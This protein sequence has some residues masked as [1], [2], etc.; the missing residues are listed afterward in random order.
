[1]K[2][3][4]GAILLFALSL[5]VFLPSINVSAGAVWSQLSKSEK[6]Q[7]KELYGY[8]I[9]QGYSDYAAAGICGN[10]DE[11]TQ[12]GGDNTT[13]KAGESRLGVF[14]E[15]AE[16][17]TKNFKP[18]AEDHHLDTKSAKVEFQWLEGC[19]DKAFKDYTTNISFKDYKKCTDLVTGVEGFMVAY[20][21]CQGG[22][23]ANYKP[24]KVKPKVNPDSLYQAGDRRYKYA[25]SIY[26]A[27]KGT[28]PE[29]DDSN[30][31]PDKTPK[32]K[33]QITNK[34]LSLGYTEDQI[35]SY[36]RLGEMN[37]EEKYLM[38]TKRNNLD[39]N[40]V[41]NLA[42]WERNVNNNKRENGFIAKL[43]VLT[44]IIG[45]FFILWVILIYIAYWFDKINSLWDLDLLGKLTFNALHVSETEEECT[46]KFNDF[47]S[48]KRKTVN[49]KAILCICVIGIVFGLL[50]FTGEFYRLISNL[51]NYVLRVLHMQ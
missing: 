26:K 13:W 35:S 40:S 10:A 7:A 11:E 27:L 17:W 19:L 39:Q 14:Q 44:M 28:D 49:H 43:R 42:N 33:Q 20:E 24:K 9:S 41:Q 48:T 36:F 3:L 25:K 4:Q 45:I 5:L 2:K 30:K 38:D 12:F 29:T 50:I 47:S 6:E 18:W 37:V 22:R 34:L 46:F 15:T 1:M 32:T 51:V 21:R 23:Y 8:L 31:D 16:N